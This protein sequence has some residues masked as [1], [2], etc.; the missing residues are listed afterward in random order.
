MADKRRK[1]RMLIAHFARLKVYHKS[2]AGHYKR[3]IV[4]DAFFRAK[5]GKVYFKFWRLNM[6]ANREFNY[7]L[8]QVQGYIALSKK[9]RLFKEWRT[10][11]L[12]QK[13]L[14]LQDKAVSR[15]H[16]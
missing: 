10:T 15:I 9:R 13:M 1:T 16:Q 3:K 6:Y 2:H 5:I 7:K 14:S 4:A 11:I 12:G 8:E